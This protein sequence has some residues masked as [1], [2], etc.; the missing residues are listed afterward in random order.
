[1][2]GPNCLTF[3]LYIS[4]KKW[5]ETMNFLKILNETNIWKNYP[6]CKELMIHGC[7]ICVSGCRVTDEILHLVPCVDSFRM[8]LRSIKLWAKSKLI[9]YTQ[10]CDVN[11]KPW[12]M[13]GQKEQ[14]LIR[15]R[16]FC[17]AFDQSLDLWSHMSICRKHISR[18]LH[19]LKAIYEY[20]NMEKADLGKHCLVFIKPGFPKWHHK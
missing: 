9:I 7:S 16:T 20:Q 11:G 10:K 15:H 14:A 19:N 2:C 3:R 13:E 8:T 5:V 4:K 12:H 17:G 1:M 6:A 18:F